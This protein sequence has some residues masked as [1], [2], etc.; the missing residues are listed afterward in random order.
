MAN[1]AIIVGVNQYWKPQ[2]NLKGAVGDAARVAHWLLG[3]KECRVPPENIFLLTRPA[4]EVP[5]PGVNYLDATADNL[6]LT[7]PEVVKHSEGVGDRLFFYFSGHGITNYEGFK[8]EQALLMADFTEVLTNKAVK[9]E[10]IEE[11]FK[12][13]G[14]RE[15]FFFID[16]C[17]NV[18]KWLYNFETAATT[19][20]L[21]TNINQIP[22]DQFIFL[23]TS[24]RSKSW[25]GLLSPDDAPGDEQGAFTGT[26]LAG[27][28]GAGS[29][30]VYDGE[31][32]EYIVR[33]ED[34]FS[35]VE[36]EILKRE[37]YIVKDPVHPV[38]QRPRLD[39][40]RSSN[41]P[42]LARLSA[43]GIKPESLELHV[44]PDS[45]WS[46]TE[47]L[48]MN[49]TGE[50][51]EIIKP[52]VG[53][54]VALP[55]LRPMKYTV[56]VSAPNHITEKKRWSF[57]LYEPRKLNIRLLPQNPAAPAPPMNSVI[58][59]PGKAMTMGAGEIITR[60][61]PEVRLLSDTDGSPDARL[62][63]TA[64]DPLVPLEVSDSTG[65]LLRSE[66][67]RIELAGLKPG[68]YRVRLVTPEGEF[69]EEVV[70]LSAGE[71]ESVQLSAPPPPQTRLMDEV[72]AKAN[73]L[74]AT[75]NTLDTS[76]TVGPIAS[77]QLST[78][79]ALAAFAANRNQ[80]W[81][82]RLKSLGVQSFREATS[83]DALCGLQIIAGIEFDDSQET[84]EF[85][86]QTR[87]RLWHHR[88][89]IPSVSQTP[90][91]LVS[92]PGIAEFAQSTGTGAH[93]LAIETAGQS[94]VV[95]PLMMLPRRLTTFV[96]HRSIAGRLRIYQ[97]MPSLAS[98]PTP[99]PDI[100]R[101]LEIIERF[102]L[103]GRLDNALRLAKDSLAI[104]GND[105]LAYCLAG[106]LA[107]KLAQ[108]ED[109]Q[110]AAANMLNFYDNFGDGHLLF[111]EQR[112]LE[113]D[114]DAAA[115]SYVAALERGLPVC[116]DGLSWLIE[117]VRRHR[118][119]H[120][121]VSLLERVAAKKINGLLWS[122]W[123]PELSQLS[124]GSPLV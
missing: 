77:A 33:A 14:F 7:I 15:Q 110:T 73:F 97:Y 41:N 120:P 25:E 56:R 65:T 52:V 91:A 29:A 74:I 19:V 94:P 49:E 50:F 80:G 119:K 10:S 6:L 54:P 11:Y 8:D 78:I 45:V 70:E 68:F 114:D 85:L 28:Q 9:L 3:A 59:Q 100:I 82:E 89:P 22:V 105:P 12:A 39:G 16:A 18:L 5:P 88:E 64:S 101:R 35:Y 31:A 108:R 87:I 62:T 79:L 34:L 115:Q 17:R 38:I 84:R 36:A 47:V 90:A 30:K 122:A 102:Y 121:Q 96:I 44:E 95:F 93:W 124:P 1:W 4:P 103:S 2:L 57:E 53:T 60:E 27:L 76:Q 75:D 32:D 13:T 112:T 67:G 106:Y 66:P 63:L 118:I 123:T 20:K 23:S 46:E 86:A 109:L 81:G 113:G 21:Q 43:D 69:V 71:N 48:I 40:E 51:D 55:L 24:P 117:G 37:I 58:T 92:V 111:A 99:Q 104:K 98:E 107:L 116:A 61:M 72:I 42:V 26:L 83:K